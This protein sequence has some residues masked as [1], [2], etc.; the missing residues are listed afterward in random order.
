MEIHVY[1][2]AVLS[3]SYVAIKP[4]YNKTHSKSLAHGFISN[5][6]I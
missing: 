5:T 3:L 6:F 4:D 1:I 2:I